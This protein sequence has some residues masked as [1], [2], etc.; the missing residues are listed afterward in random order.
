[1]AYWLTLDNLD[2]SDGTHDVD[3]A[4][5]LGDDSPLT[6]DRGYA[7]VDDE[8]TADDLARRYV[9]VERARPPDWAAEDREED[10]P[11]AEEQAEERDDIDADDVGEGGGGEADIG[12]QTHAEE[13]GIGDEDGDR[14]EQAADT[15]EA[16]A[17]APFDPSEYTI[18]ELDGELDSRNLDSDDLDALA[19]AERDGEDREGALET[20]D[21]H[22][23]EGGTE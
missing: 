13:R 9:H 15:D 11:S 4:Q 20:I 18:D 10:A 21:D 23:S 22:R 3:A 19:A 2:E 8:E 7:S 16:A 1:M 14:A 6:F 5:V 12:E 17:D